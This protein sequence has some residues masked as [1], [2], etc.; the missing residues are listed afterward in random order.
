MRFAEAQETME[1]WQARTMTEW[2]EIAFMGYGREAPSKSFGKTRK[3]NE[4]PIFIKVF[5]D[6]A[7]GKF[8]FGLG[9]GHQRHAH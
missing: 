7:V 1:K 9:P 3:D 6:H 5:F 4:L 8:L 2:L